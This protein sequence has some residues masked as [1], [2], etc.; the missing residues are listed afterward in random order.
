MPISQIIDYDLAANFTFDPVKV[1]IVG[2]VARLKLL[3]LDEDYN[4]PFASDAGFTYD[5]G[6]TEFVGGEVRQK[7]QLEGGETFRARYNMASVNALYAAGS[8][9][10]TAKNGAVVSGGKLVMTGAAA[11][12]Y[13]DYAGAGNIDASPQVGTRRFKVTPAYSG[14]P[15]SKTQF[16]YSEGQAEGSPN[17]FLAIHHDTTSGNLRIAMADQAGVSHTQI[18]GVWSPTAGVEYEFELNFDFTA[19]AQRLFI[20][21]VQFGTTRTETFTRSSTI[22]IMRLGNT[23]STVGGAS[24]F[25]A[26]HSIDDVQAFTTVKHTANYT[27]GTIANLYTTDAVA[28][29][30]FTHAGPVGSVIKSL[31]GFSTSETSVPRYT[32][33]VDGGAELYWN[34]SA[35]AASSSTYATA[36]SAADVAANLGTVPGVD[37]A[38]TL[39]VTIYW[40]SS[41]VRSAVAD[42]TLETTAETTY[43]T[44][45]P[46]IRPVAT[47]PADALLS[48]TA[49]DTVA[50]SDEVRWTVRVDGVEQWWNGAAWVASSG[51]LAETNT[52]TEINDNAAALDISSGASITVTAYLHS[53][54][55][56]T[57]PELEQSTFS[58]SFFVPTATAPNQCVVYGW[59]LELDGSPRVG[60][61]VEVDAPRFVHGSYVVNFSASVVTDATGYWELSIVET[62]SIGV[63]PYRFKIDGEPFALDVQV[64]DQLSA[65]FEELES[66]F[67]AAV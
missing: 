10:G 51:A 13:V 38:N 65:A 16:F 1:E 56:S 40:T 62:E 36:S 45:D 29:P 49:T 57:S 18:L 25:Q 59:F 66:I 61:T 32:I 41:D 35:W 50:G 37:G 48:F 34:G 46:T 20:N 42:L 19:G 7:A 33:A 28:L 54:D 15:A 67:V 9:T 63:S 11:N 31:D 26:N 64:P 22:G 21:G 2:G 17:N 6:K 27:P 55:G 4:E 58:Y 23:S 12:K 30:T 60:A 53:D 44:D 24:S 39:D 8:P 14:A 52:A 43:P 3:E 47:I 5:A